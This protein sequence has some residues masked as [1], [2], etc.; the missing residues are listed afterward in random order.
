MKALNAGLLLVG[1]VVACGLALHL[2]EPPPVPVTA[3]LRPQPAVPPA[4]L[5]A[6]EPASPPPPVVRW[7]AAEPAV[8]SA[9]PPVFTEPKPSPLPRPAAKIEPPPRPIVKVEPPPR[10]VA[11]P[12]PV[13]Y[14]EPPTPPAPKPDPARHV[15][16]QTGDAVAVRVAAPLSA[17]H[18]SLGELFHGVLAEPLIADG[19]VVG[20]RGAQVSGRVIAID[21]DRLTLRLLNFQTADGQ[22]IEISTEPV[23]ILSGNILRFRLAARVTITERKT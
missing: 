19:L 17:E 16:L 8:E 1:T 23:T 3:P 20:E 15:T 10:P 22:R 5:P 13:P 11:M 4:P 18:M 6:P 7:R 2:T 21:R 9:P 12:R 14:Q